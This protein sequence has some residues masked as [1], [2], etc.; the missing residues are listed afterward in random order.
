MAED[1]AQETPIVLLCAA[2]GTQLTATAKSLSSDEGVLVSDLERELCKEYVFH[3]GIRLPPE[4]IDDDDSRIPTM[5]V[6]ARKRRR[7]LYKKW[8]AA[9]GRIIDKHRK[10]QSALVHVVSMHLTWHHPETREFYSPVNVPSLAD[11]RHPVRH[12][13]I[14]IDDIYDMYSRLTKEFNLYDI[15]AREVLRDGFAKLSGDKEEAS[16]TGNEEDIEEHEEKKERK[17]IEQEYGVQCVEYAL[18]ELMAWRRAEM[19]QAENV[20]RSLGCDLT[21]LGSKHSYRA[22][23]ALISSTRVPRIYLSHRIT[24]LRKANIASINEDRP[25]GR[26]YPVAKEVN[27]LHDLLAKKGQ[28]LINPT[29]ID[30]LRFANLTDADKRSPRLAP[31]WPLPG[32]VEDLMWSLPD[33]VDSEHFKLL[34]GN[35]DLYNDI[36][37]NVARSLSNRIYHEVSFRDHAIVENT[38]N[39]CVYRPFFCVDIEDAPTKSTWSGG[40]GPEIDHWLKEATPPTTVLDEGVDPAQ[41]ILELALDDSDK[42]DHRRLAFANTM[43]E[44]EGR[45]KFLTNESDALEKADFADTIRRHMKAALSEWEVSDDGDYK[46]ALEAM[47]ADQRGSTHLRGGPIPQFMQ[48]YPEMLIDALHA[49]FF[50][51]LY[52]AFT[53][54]DRSQRDPLS[55]LDTKFETMEDCIEAVAST[56]SDVALFLFEESNT[57]RVTVLQTLAD[58]LAKFFA[59]DADVRSR[60]VT[61]WRHCVSKFEESTGKAVGHFASATIGIDYATL[62]AQLNREELRL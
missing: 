39:L 49:A 3:K 53:M 23:E 50:T 57:R 36:A 9:Y 13:I 34:C 61:F 45:I 62:C 38:P 6:A 27:S 31:R 30:E 48:D 37:S 55:S 58:D 15:K 42:T 32:N 43:T 14:L 24:E 18:G 25:L 12:I 59:G 1:T 20:A 26:W 11:D 5:Y 44:I 35:L 4:E 33:S 22:L 19:I 10:Y 21:I 29:A 60:N 2:P 46:L 28:V 47:F 56:S 40:V 54:M 51:A 16:Y 41:E 52:H 8:R 17:R 7:E